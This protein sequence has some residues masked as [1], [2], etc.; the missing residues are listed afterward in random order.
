MKKILLNIIHIII[1]SFIIGCTT[2]PYIVPEF[3]NNE[4]WDKIYEK[5]YKM[6]N[7][8]VVVHISFS[9]ISIIGNDQIDIKYCNLFIE[10]IE[11][12]LRQPV[13]NLF[14]A[15]QSLLPGESYKLRI[16]INDK[17]YETQFKMPNETTIK[18]T[19]IV[20]KSSIYYK[21]SWSIKQDY[22]AQFVGIILERNDVAEPITGYILAEIK[23]QSRSYIFSPNIIP[24]RYT[25]KGVTVGGLNYDVN[26]DI[27]F[28]SK[29]DNYILS[30]E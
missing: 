5:Y 26:N 24:S 13:Q 29:I 30:E 28:I 23:P 27:L 8:D 4:I 19:R 20:S 21:F 16:L 18:L 12:E 9:S 15:N 6:E 10:D 7:I 1:L 3:I 11:I 2:E 22:D 14:I 17:S 25:F